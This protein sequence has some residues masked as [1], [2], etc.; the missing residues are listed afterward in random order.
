MPRYA[1]FLRAVNLGSTRKT[2]SAE[3]KTAFG[4]MGFE[5]V[6]TF[7]TSGNVVFDAPREPESKLCGRIEA[8]LEKEFGFE[9]PVYLR[10]EKQ[11]LAIVAQ[12]PFTKKQLDASNGKLQVSLLS[13]KPA[14]KAAERVLALAT[15][16]DPLKLAGR[17]LYWLPK[18]GTLESE[19]DLKAIDNLVGPI[20]RRTM[21]TIELIAQ[22]HFAG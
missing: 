10:D 7:R 13:R 6:A 19:L 11:V 12:R 17:E 15:K 18:G 1:A 16:D 14:K 22:K 20:T 8:A 21:G 3:L 2:S 5:D 4:E 9:V